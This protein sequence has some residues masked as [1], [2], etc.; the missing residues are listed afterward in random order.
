[1][2]ADHGIDFDAASSAWMENKIRRGP[3][4]VYRCQ[5]FK[6]TGDGARCS[7]PALKV[8]ASAS[9]KPHLCSVHVYAWKYNKKSMKLA[10]S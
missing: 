6:T 9:D 7:R 8:D 2:M 1:M 3:S 4:M 5:A 10:A